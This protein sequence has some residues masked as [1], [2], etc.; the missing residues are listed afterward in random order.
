[1]TDLLGLPTSIE[2]PSRNKDYPGKSLL[3]NTLVHVAVFDGEP[4]AINER[5]DKCIQEVLGH[6][7]VKWSQYA[8]VGI[9][10][11]KSDGS[12]KCFI[13][14]EGSSIAKSTFA[15]R[16]TFKIVARG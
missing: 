15:R 11:I 13:D 5:L 12:R 10:F 1:M 7:A 3:I 14:I 8:L 16:F 9:I 6:I 2:I 4:N